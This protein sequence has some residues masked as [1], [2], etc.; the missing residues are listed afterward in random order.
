MPGSIRQLW[1]EAYTF[2]S[3]GGQSSTGVLQR[4]VG[5]SITTT[6]AAS[7]LT[8]RSG[9]CYLLAA[10]TDCSLASIV[11]LAKDTAVDVVV[12]SY[13][14]R[15]MIHPMDEIHKGMLS[16]N[17]HVSPTEKR[18]SV[19]VF[20][21]SCCNGHLRFSRFS[22]RSPPILLLSSPKRKKCRPP[23]LKISRILYITF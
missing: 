20:T 10:D 12:K 3:F 6:R 19:G 13:F 15:V 21:P 18:P 8:G 1:R 14:T 11:M 2:L 22:M 7:S 17:P 4:M 16:N 23:D 9:S 5:P